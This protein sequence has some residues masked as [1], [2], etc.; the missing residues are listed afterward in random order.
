MD[1]GKE[2]GEINFK[3]LPEFEKQYFRIK[4]VAR[5][6]RPYQT[7]AQNKRSRPPKKQIIQEFK[8]RIINLRKSIL[9]EKRYSFI[10]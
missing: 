5:K 2:T 4:K 7:N 10:M 9:L 6:L 1:L 8:A 3:A